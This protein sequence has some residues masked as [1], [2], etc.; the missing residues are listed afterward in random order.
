MREWDDPFNPFNSWKALTHGPHFK[1]ILAEDYL[2]PVVVNLDVSGMCQY[3]CPHC[4]H[5][6]K[7]IKD[8]SLPEL[9]SRLA[10]TFPAFLEGWERRGHRPRGCCIVGSQGDALLF[11][12]LPTLLRELHH[13]GVQV[14]L[15]SNGYG[16][17]DQLLDYA[18]HYCK[19]VGFSMDAG[20][21]E[22]YAAVHNPP[23]GAFQRVCANIAQLTLKLQDLKLRNDVGFKFLI[24]PQSYQT[25]F[26][27]AKLAKSLGCRYMQI[28]PADLPEEARAQID[29]D[30]VNEQIEQAMELNVSGRFEVV[31]VRH[32]FTNDFKRKLPAYCW[33]TALTVTITSDGKCW[34][35]VDRRW[36]T[37]TL[38]ADCGSGAGW[39]ALRDAWGSAQHVNTV[40]SIINCDGA[41]PKCNIRCSNYGYD[42]LFNRVFLEDA[43][44]HVL[45]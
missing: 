5:R 42:A 2:P 24:L 19:F 29:I 33:L 23:P 13:V 28:R 22:T 21:R 20:T 38:L 17:T 43:M 18:A 11:K 16:Y 3:R 25:L 26:E 1:A 12:G 15:V 14:G 7:Q 45:I 4:H 8:R 10:R 6:A 34:P 37:E 35:C 40:H 32:K 41:G 30:V 27:A 36:D 39:S 9:S 44:D 31:G